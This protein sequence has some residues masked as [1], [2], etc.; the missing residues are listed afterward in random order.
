VNIR[1]SFTS[2]ETRRIVLP[3]AEN[4]TIVSSFVWTQ[5]RSGVTKGGA[6]DTLQGRGDTRMKKGQLLK[7]YMG[8]WFGYTV[9]L[10]DGDD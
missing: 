10:T 7:E 8:Y 5:Y 1:I 2:S 3:D 6:G 4:R 9:E